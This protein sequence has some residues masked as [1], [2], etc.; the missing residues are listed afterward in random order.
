MAQNLADNDSRFVVLQN[1][2]HGIVDALNTGLAR[3]RDGIVFRMD[4]DD[5]M[6][7]QR[8]ARQT[9]H[10]QSV[11]ISSSTVE[12][13]GSMTEGRRQYFEWQNQVR[14]INDIYASRYI[15][16][17][18]QHPTLAFR[19]STIERLGGYRAGPFPEDYDLILRALQYGFTMEKLAEPLLQ[20]RCSE[21]Q[22]SYADE[23]YGRSAFHELRKFHLQSDTSLL[24]ILAGRPLV[25]WGASRMSRRRMEDHFAGSEIVQRIGYFVDIRPGQQENSTLDVRS[26]GDL[27]SDVSHPFVLV[28]VN[29]RGA[30]PIIESDL[31]R[32]G[33]T[34][35]SD[36]LCI[37]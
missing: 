12:P 9:D 32:H 26:P 1:D 13:F 18:A 17:P 28:Y 6:H 20:Y 16:C 10:L 35:G 2:G 24:A 23:R 19:T 30:R 4:A 3:C 8:L 5:R 33:W 14:S 36:Y 31:Q 22:L 7:P 29:A 25:V 34:P 15:E 11:D 27:Y 37:G 21:S